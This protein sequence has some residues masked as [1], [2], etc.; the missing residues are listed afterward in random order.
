MNDHLWNET[1]NTC[2]SHDIFSEVNSWSSLAPQPL[3]ADH[4]FRTLT[5]FT[6]KPQQD[7]ANSTVSSEGQHDV[8]SPGQLQDQQDVFHWFILIAQRANGRYVAVCS[9]WPMAWEEEKKKNKIMKLKG[10]VET[11]LL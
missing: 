10:K 11:M 9:E 2:P 7:L 1:V 8:K 6:K 3:E 5:F 4:L